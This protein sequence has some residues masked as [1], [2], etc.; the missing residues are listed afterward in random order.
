MAN[1]L[2]MAKKPDRE[3]YQQHL[4]LVLI[5]IAGVGAIGFTVHFVFSVFTVGK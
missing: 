3:E 5:G 2:K 4:R 1:T